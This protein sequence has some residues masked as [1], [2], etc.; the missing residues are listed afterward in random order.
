[1]NGIIT[2]AF[3]A[4]ILLIVL[5]II[6]TYIFTKINRL[7]KI[8]LKQLDYYWLTLSAFAIFGLV[9]KNRIQLNEIELA[10]SKWYHQGRCYEL[11]NAID[12]T[13]ICFKYTKIEYSPSNFDELQKMTDSL[14]TWTKSIIP[15]LKEKINGNDRINILVPLVNDRFLIQYTN[16]VNH[17][18]KEYNDSLQEILRLNSETK[19]NDFSFIIQMLSPILLILGLAIRFSKTAAEIMLEKKASNLNN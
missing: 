9:E 18:V 7:N 12:S 2:N 5:T 4:I 16:R 15:I 19:I 3:L 10:K 11:I 1:M 8:Q 14:C 17:V 6:F 13:S